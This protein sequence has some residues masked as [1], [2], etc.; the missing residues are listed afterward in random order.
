M[1]A[2]QIAMLGVGLGFLLIALLLYVVPRIAA[3][4]P[5]EDEERYRV[6]R[7]AP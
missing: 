1:N 4:D 5:Y 7:G 6:K 3:P 2:L